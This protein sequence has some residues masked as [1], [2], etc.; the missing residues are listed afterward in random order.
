MV[1]EE[2]VL[3][4]SP[5]CRKTSDRRMVLEIWVDRGADEPGHFGAHAV[6]CGQGRISHA[7]VDEPL[8]QGDVELIL[9]R[10]LV[11]SRV[12]SKLLMVTCVKSNLFQIWCGDRTS[13]GHTYVTDGVRP[14]IRSYLVSLRNGPK[15]EFS[16]LVIIPHH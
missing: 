16:N 11:N 15:T 14:S 9:N 3:C 1:H 13:D 2:D 7:V 5:D 6:L 10:Q 4:N 8:E 12:R